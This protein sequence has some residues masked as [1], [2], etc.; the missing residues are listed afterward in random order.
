[1]ANAIVQSATIQ[2]KDQGGGVFGSVPVADDFYVLPIPLDDPNA[3]Y[4]SFADGND[5]NDGIRVI[6]GGTGPWK[7]F[8]TAFPA[9]TPDNVLYCF[10]KPLLQADLDMKFIGS[11]SATEISL[12]IITRH[13]DVSIDDAGIDFNGFSIIRWDQ[14]HWWQFQNLT[15]DDSNMSVG[16]D[17]TSTGAAF[18]RMRINMLRFSTVGDNFGALQFLATAQDYEL[19]DLTITGPGFDGGATIGLNTA[20][21]IMFE[22]DRATINRLTL[23]NAPIP[24]YC[25]HGNDVLEANVDLTISNIFI[26]ESDRNPCQMNLNWAQCSNW[27]IGK[28]NLTGISVSEDNGVAGGD[29][30]TF[31]HFTFFNRSFGFNSSSQSPPGAVNDTVTNCVLP[32]K[33]TS[34]IS[35]GN[36]NITSDNNAFGDTG[37]AYSIIGVDKPLA[38]W[39]TESSQDAS[40]IDGTL[41]FVGGAT[42]VTVADYALASDSIGF[43]TGVGADVAL[44]GSRV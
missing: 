22:T 12:I 29:N 31:D 23:K 19:E 37:A 43:G 14:K 13:P 39:K 30:T 40:S 34:A 21:L 27:V 8:E 20:C 38:T 4:I 32:I 1:M 15:F 44:C 2:L 18:R 33:T 17:I 10:D 25:K 41:T 16:Q 35:I 6:D 3:R 28:N 7:H 11:N 36:L 42:P 24:L 5:S 9:L 26:D